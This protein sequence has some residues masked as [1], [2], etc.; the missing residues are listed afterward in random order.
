[1]SIAATSDLEHAPTRLLLVPL[2]SAIA[3]VA[4]ADWLF[5]GW[6]VGISLALFLGVLGVV[7]VASNGV[8]AGRH[9]Q[10]VMGT[11]FVAGLARRQYAVEDHRH[12]RNRDVRHH[13]DHQRTIILAARLV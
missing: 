6:D 7:A 3:C 5:F 4:L 1:M 11:V 8:R 2:T 10:I 12:A 13:H 9:I